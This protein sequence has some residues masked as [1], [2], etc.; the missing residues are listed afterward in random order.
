MYAAA[1]ALRKQV[2]KSMTGRTESIE[3]DP[4]LQLE[5]VWSSQ[6]LAVSVRIR[7]THFGW[8]S[9]RLRAQI[10]KNVFSKFKA[11]YREVNDDH[12]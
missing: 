6:E 9:K 12:R 4:F 11:S 1:S 7:S 5:F 2:R 8:L 10:L 3:F